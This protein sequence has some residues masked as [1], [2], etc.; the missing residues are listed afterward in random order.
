M[1]SASRFLPPAVGA[2]AGA[3][4]TAAAV[5]LLALPLLGPA[6]V[7]A[8]QECHF[9]EP[10]GG[11]GTTPIVS[12]RVGP[13]RL[14]GRTNWNTDFVVD[15][16]YRSF[17]FF[18]TA[19]STDPRARYPVSGWMKFTDGSSLRL[20]EQILSPPVGRGRQFG[21]FAAVPGKQASQMNFRIGAANQPG[22]LG[23]SYRISVQGCL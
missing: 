9:L 21:P 2:T 8:A 11:N 23:F 14:L 16:P 17:R 1:T 13:G 12:K 22:A 4:A 6:P 7:R 3:V 19:T 20:F 5:G 10:V 15:R 18:F